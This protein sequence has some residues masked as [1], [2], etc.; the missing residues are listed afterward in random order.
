MSKPRK[1]KAPRADKPARLSA[2]EAQLARPSGGAAELEARP[3]SETL[4]E[5]QVHQIELEMQ[6]Q[7]LKETRLAL[8]ESR[9]RYLDLYDFGPLGY[10]TFTREGRILEVNLTGAGLLGLPRAELLGRGLEG[11]VASEDRDRWEGYLGTVL[12]SAATSRAPRERPS[13]ELKLRRQDGSVFHARLE[14]LRLERAGAKESA[15]AE[16]SIIRTAMSDISERQAAEAHLAWLGS[17]P[18]KNPNPIAE[19][20]VAS[21]VVRFA[22]PSAQRLFPD[23]VRQG[24][25]HPWL[26][27]ARETA[28]TL[29]GRRDGALRREV[30]VGETHY[31]QTLSL[32]PDRK[33][34]RVYGMDI[35]QRKQAELALRRA[36]ARLALAQQ[37]AAIGTWDY[38]VPTGKLDWSPEMFR[39]LGLDP[40]RTEAS[41]EVWRQ[42]VHPEDLPAAAERIDAAI[43]D[44]TPLANEYRIVRST[45]EV[46]WINALGQTT[47]D[48][49]GQALRMA[50][51]CLD[52]TERKQAADALAVASEQRRLMLEASGMGAWDY[53]FDT[54]EVFWD[55]RC[56]NQWGILQGDQIDYAAALGAI[57]PD[58]RA[59]TD[60]AVKRALAGEEGGA[61]QREFR[62][63]WPN[64][65]VHWIDSHGQVYFE[66]ESEG[67]HAVRFIGANRDICERKMSEQARE[68]LSACGYQGS[69]E[70]FFQAL[71]RY[72]AQSLGMDYVCIDRLEGDGLVAQTVAVYFDGKFEENVTYAL[73][74]TPCGEVV[75]K[76]IC[77]FP[78]GVRHLFPR[79]V[80]LQEMRA[81]SY[82]GTI[83][84]GYDGE[85]IGLIAVI[86]RRP[87]SNPRL[88]ESVLRLVAVRA[89]GELQRRHAEEALRSSEA[90]FRLVLEHSNDAIFWADP[91]TGILVRCN[92]K[93][94]ELTG[95]TRDELIGMHQSRLHPPDPY[96]GEIFRKAAGLPTAENIEAEVLSRTGKR[97][98]V[99]INSSVVTF[100]QRRIIQG[101]FRDVTELK[102]IQESLRRAKDELEARVEQR[103]RDL[104]ETVSRL[105]SEIAA[106]M[107]VEAELRETEER[108]R[109]LFAAAPVGIALTDASGRVHDANAALCAMLGISL[110][111]AQAA[112]AGS[113]YAKPADRHRLMTRVRRETRVEDFE[114]VLRRKDGTQFLASLKLNWIQLRSEQRFLTLVT[115]LTRRRVAERHIQG[116]AALQEL[117]VTQVTRGEYLNAVVRFLREW[118]G[119]ACAGIRLLDAEGNLPFEASVGF[120]RAFLKEEGRSCFDVASCPCLPALKKSSDRIEAPFT[121]IQST[122][123]RNELG[124]I[125]EQSPA[126]G[127]PRVTTPCERARYASLAHAP[128]KYRN[129]ILGIILLADRRDGKFPLEVAQ[130]LDS[131][132]PLVGEAL[133]RFSLES[134]LRES[135]ERFRSLFERHQSVMLLVDPKSGVIVDA[136]E[137]AERYYGY[138]R[139][140][141]TTLSIKDLNV[142]SPPGIGSGAADAVLGWERRAVF[143]QRLANGETRTVEMHSSPIA[144]RERTL[145]FSIIHD[146]TERRRLERQVLDIGDRERRRI[147]RDLHDSLGGGLSGLAMLS[148]ALAQSLARSS[149]PE[150]TIAEEIV[151][152][153][154]EAVRRTRAIARGL[155][156]VGLSAYGL[157]NGL[158]ELARSVAKRHGIQCQVRAPQEVVIEAD[159]TASHLFQ[160]V[161]EAVNNAIRHGRARRIEITVDR[162]PAGLLVSI[163][164]DGV[165]MPRK[166]EDSPGMGLRTM[167]YRAGV[168]GATFEIHSP[169][170]GGTIVSCL[171][172]AAGPP[173][174]TTPSTCLRP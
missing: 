1:A 115:D 49:R 50:G 148:K 131:A 99:I 9:D 162:Q 37:A 43:R 82:A 128:I 107:Q 104:A 5:L 27:G 142:Q 103:T 127:A 35:T 113:F 117:F 40:G 109:T 101:I 136:N 66:G 171:M 158:E 13:C 47:Y 98:P 58:D 85:P 78:Q 83:L 106:R 150:A 88:A 102:Q 67:R 154:N 68:F 135:E 165:G 110:T 63:V 81:E 53:R 87:L 100:G 105:E 156:P 126:A 140:R 28:G 96:Y 52:V 92:R 61:Y 146:I 141:L 60:E 166:L 8:E 18:E 46:R 79:D 94:E 147:G 173:N 86:G 3:A 149:I 145:L 55:E 80:V 70:D 14:S 7:E 174:E 143:R 130:F 41:F 10:F 72:L 114:T 122:I 56:R 167:R 170:T 125:P 77:C 31:D 4:H 19:I 69:G 65:A 16:H 34:L 22:N 112:E 30:A 155:C 97:T 39:L 144:V 21:G 133:H 38:D 54:G 91:E 48:D 132:A 108:Y 6:N 134:E 59:A 74:D 36:H 57:H 124:D 123:V 23:L 161:E 51:V 29:R 139:G 164:D 168:M 137:A 20:E 111:E 62:V 33:W 169:P 153:I 76:T 32:S 116:I 119:C 44:R 159:F 172:P 25:A 121:R 26:A 93:A 12:Q 95:R 163:R 2:A 129:R 42:V 17:F 152:G 90:E 15:G 118:S 64:G 120:T 84:Q 138:P 75:G 24:A 45:G 11:F 89:A 160:I 73:K 71:A 157:I 151:Q